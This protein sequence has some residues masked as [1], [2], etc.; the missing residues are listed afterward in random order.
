MVYYY[1][2]S[3]MT[4]HFLVKIFLGFAP[5]P[6]RLDFGE[7][8]SAADTSVTDQ[9]S[10]HKGNRQSKG[11]APPI[12]TQHPHRNDQVTCVMNQVDYQN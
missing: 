11:P 3:K 4:Y 1:S 2:V 6:T 5:R 9:V 12:P 8:P 10:P 7:S